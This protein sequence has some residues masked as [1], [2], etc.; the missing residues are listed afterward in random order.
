MVFTLLFK[1]ADGRR[2]PRNIRLDVTPVGAGHMTTTEVNNP[3]TR[4]R[5]PTSEW[6]VRDC[7]SLFFSVSCQQFELWRA[8]KRSLKWNPVSFW[9]TTSGPLPV[10][11]S[12]FPCAQWGARGSEMWGGLPVSKVNVVLVMAYGSLVSLL[13]LTSCS[14]ALMTEE[15]AVWKRILESW[16][17]YK[18]SPLHWSG[19][20]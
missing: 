15:A 20:Y 8:A 14:L 16:P 7:S 18:S 13:V 10:V 4:W 3:R 6:A 9:R 11:Y 1:T 19:H 17:A 5:N 12:A 2:G